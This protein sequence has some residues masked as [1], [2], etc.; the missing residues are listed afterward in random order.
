[1]IQYPPTI[2]Y[3]YGLLGESTKNSMPKDIMTQSI[4]IVYPPAILT[5]PDAIGLLHFFG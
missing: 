2:K 5:L 1:M 4:I 3:R